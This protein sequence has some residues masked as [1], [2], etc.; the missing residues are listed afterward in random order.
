MEELI[1]MPKS[2]FLRVACK[3]CKNDQIVFDKASTLVKCMKC[4]AELVI[5]T[6]GKSEIY[7][8]ILQT[9]S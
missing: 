9:L 1:Q 3:N 7:G 6:G 4:N 5:P 8:K 2:K